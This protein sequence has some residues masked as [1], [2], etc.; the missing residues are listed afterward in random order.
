MFH[1]EIAFESRPASV[2]AARRFVLEALA[3]A[4]ASAEAWAAAHAVSELATNAVVHAGTPY[5]VRVFVDDSAVRV[6]VTDGLPAT[7][8]TALAVTTATTGRGLRLVASLSRDWGID[9]GLATKTVWCEIARVPSETSGRDVG[10]LSVRLHAREHADG[11]VTAGPRD[12]AD[13][14][15][16]ADARTMRCR[17]VA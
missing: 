11:A 2:A 9:A 12:T 7:D 6:A 1:A 16:S 3:S 17:D 10:E 13:D 15:P 4:G 14:A 5:L 8:V